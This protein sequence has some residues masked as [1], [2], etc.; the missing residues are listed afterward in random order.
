VALKLALPALLL[1]AGSLALLAARDNRLSTLFA[2]LALHGIAC[3]C[4]APTL[5]LLLPRRYAAPRRWLL[6]FLFACLFFMPLAS[7]LCGLFGLLLWFCLPRAAQQ[8][9]YGSVEPPRFTTQR[10]QEGSGFR[11]GQVRARLGNAQAPL[12]QRMKALVALQ[13]TPAHATGELLRKLLADPADD[14]RLLAYGILDN[15]EKAVMQRIRAAQA[16]LEAARSDAERHAGHK[17]IAELYFELIYQNLVQGDMRRFAADQVRSHIGDA[18][19]SSQADAGLWFMLARLELQ[20]GNADAAESALARAADAG[21]ARTRL[22]PYLAELR[23]LQR[24][25]EEVRRM[26]GELQDDATLPAIAAMRRYWRASGAPS[27]D[28]Y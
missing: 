2:Y 17:R 12:E 11:G 16:E 23:F 14:I 21:F 4:A 13:D 25:H 5:A 7:L 1:E 6:P 3:A 24:R 28:G 20:A 10:Q 22:L 9:D 27:K 26:F 19:R 8:R 18:H 15:K